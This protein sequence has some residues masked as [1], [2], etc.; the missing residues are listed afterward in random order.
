MGNALTIK[1]F[2]LANI[3]DALSTSLALNLG[4]TEANPIINFVME[5]TSVPEALLVKLAV[6]A[7]VGLLI[8]RWKPRV[9]RAATLVISLIAISN[10]LVSLGYL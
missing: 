6:A 8:S 3:S 4:G 9:L 2:I 7:G 10:S 1:T 5:A